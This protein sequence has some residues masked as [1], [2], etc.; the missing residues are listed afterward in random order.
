MDEG[1]K[2]IRLQLYLA[3]AGIGSRRKCEKYISEG[4]ASVNGR[5]VSGQGFKV[6]PGDRVTFDGRLVTE[7]RKKC[8]LAVY[9]P[10]GYLC[11]NSDRFNRPLVLD[12]LKYRI[13][14][15]LFHVG[16]LD[17]LSS[18]LIFYTN[19]GDFAAA[20]SHP[21]SEIEK[22]YRVCADR[23]VSDSLLRRFR[24]GVEIDG[25]IY[26]LKTYG[27]ITAT[28]VKIV[29]IEGKNREIR[30]VFET[31]GLRIRELIRVRVGQ[32]T[33]DGLSEGE[34][35]D[36]TIGERKSLLSKGVSCGSGD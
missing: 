34:Y 28:T 1:N 13:R 12:L 26:R 5:T 8:Y 15:R 29:L 6:Q 22:E 19:D 36:L 9:K 24:E 20:V 16:R 14:E 23:P 10:A 7:E 30:R 35:R 3:R 17:L 27:R 33:L 4:R 25:V 11:S 31:A 21:S 32:V 18:G 2:A